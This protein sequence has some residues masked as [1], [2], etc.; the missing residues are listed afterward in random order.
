MFSQLLTHFDPLAATIAEAPTAVRRLSDLRGYFADQDA[1]EQRLAADDPIVY[2]IASVEPAQGEGQLHYGLGMIAPGRIGDEYFMTKGHYHAWR[3]AAEFY[4][5]LSG[6]GLMLLE[7]EQ[8]GESTVL[9]LTPN[10]VVYVPG[11]T[12]HRT[13]NVGDVPLTYLGIYPALAGHDYGAIAER[14][15]HS[16]VVASGGKPV[17]LRR[18]AYLAGLR[19]TSGTRS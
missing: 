7:D 6:S 14:N 16:V 11:Y 3:P 2:T 9:P 4:I 19:P 15:F 13:L 10:S 8:S 12:A 1:Y 17:Q 5:G 18:D